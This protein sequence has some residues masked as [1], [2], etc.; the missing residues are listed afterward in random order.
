VRLRGAGFAVFCRNAETPGPGRVGFSVPRRVGNAVVRSRVKRRLRE[1][2]RRYWNQ[3]PDGC[4]LV[5]HVYPAIVDATAAE[6]EAQ[7]ERALHESSRAL[8]RSRDSRS[9]PRRPASSG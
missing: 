7:I 4:E 8:R 3:L 2:I 9:Q 1:L 6:L 5:F